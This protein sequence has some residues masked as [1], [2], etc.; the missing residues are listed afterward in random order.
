[1]SNQKTFLKILGIA[2]LVG[3]IFGLALF[4]SP[5]YS[6]AY[7]Q[8]YGAEHKSY[9]EI[10]ENK[11]IQLYEERPQLNPLTPQLQEEAALA[12]EYR[13][14]PEFI[15]EQ[16]RMFA[17]SLYF[18]TLNSVIFILFLLSFIYRPI[19]GFL[20]AQASQIS[21]DLEKADQLREDSNKVRSAAQ[22]KMDTW[23]STEDQVK[24]E[25][26]D[27]IQRQ[28]AQINQEFELARTTLE[29]E[30]KERKQAELY[31]GARALR[32]E[33][34][35]ET[36]SRLEQRYRDEAT[37]QRLTE[38]VKEFTRLMETLS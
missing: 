16:R 34:V 13:L 6:A 3:V 18:K 35:A 20:D 7:L 36:I 30:T 19:V 37:Q 8:K 5:N 27:L 33:F 26:A 29:R 9:R 12:K 25:N 31:R 32:G 22:A 23:T 17:Y 15:A 38:S 2:Y 4:R 1:M 28:L 14:R 24:K 10:L 11:A 21:T